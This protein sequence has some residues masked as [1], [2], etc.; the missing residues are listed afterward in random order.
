MDATN[1]AGTH[2]AVWW[3]FKQHHRIYT[4]ATGG[5]CGIVPFAAEI[6]DVGWPYVAATDGKSLRVYALDPGR[7]STNLREVA[8]L[9]CRA[10]AMVFVDGRTLFV[11]YLRG[12]KNERW[13]ALL[14]IGTRVRRIKE[15]PL[16]ADKVLSVSRT[17]MQIDGYGVYYDMLHGVLVKPSDAELLA[18][19]QPHRRYQ[20][21]RMYYPPGLKVAVAPCRVTVRAVTTNLLL[22]TYFGAGV[23]VSADGRRAITR[24][25]HGPV[26]WHAPKFQFKTDTLRCPDNDLL[27]TRA[28]AFCTDALRLPPIIAGAVAR[29][30]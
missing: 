17:L 29:W 5:L 30:W 10:Q 13:W 22:A 20:H 11:E 8:R 12:A 19:R 21:S 6:I 3:E 9:T 23:A 24:R 25:C 28:Y 15:G 27:Q 4:T 26:D 1:T 18:L 7:A 16:G 2:V 14:R